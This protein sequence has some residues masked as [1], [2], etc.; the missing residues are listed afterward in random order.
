MVHTQAKIRTRFVSRRMDWVRNSCSTACRNL[1]KHNTYLF[2]FGTRDSRVVNITVMP[3]IE[4]HYL[5]MRVSTT[6]T[7]AKYLL[8]VLG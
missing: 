7:S 1:Y 5:P 8:Y 4:N 3:A 6:Y 2:V